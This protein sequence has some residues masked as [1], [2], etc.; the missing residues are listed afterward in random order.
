MRG[1]TYVAVVDLPAS[2]WRSFAVPS[3]DVR[4]S[5]VKGT[6]RVLSATARGPV[7]A[8]P[9]AIDTAAAA[10]AEARKTTPSRTDSV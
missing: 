4:H 1:R 9:S 10:D 5:V 8:L 2:E 7:S 3:P 6:F